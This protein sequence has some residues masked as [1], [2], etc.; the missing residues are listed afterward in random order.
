MSCRSPRERQQPAQDSTVPAGVPSSPTPWSLN[1]WTEKAL[2][3]SSAHP[4]ANGGISVRQRSRKHACHQLP[5]AT[6][7]PLRCPRKKHRKATAARVSRKAATGYTEGPS[8]HVSRSREGTAWH[9]A[10]LQS[11]P[12]P[13]PPS[14][15]PAFRCP[16]LPYSTHLGIL[17]SLRPGGS[18]VRQPL[19]FSVLLHHLKHELEGFPG[20][21]AHVLRQVGQLAALCPK[22]RGEERRGGGRIARRRRTWGAAWE[23]TC[24]YLLLRRGWI[25]IAIASTGHNASLLALRGCRHREGRRRTVH[26]FPGLE[27]FTGTT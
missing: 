22:R 23:S 14:P 27:A 2:F 1:D 19:R 6:Q 16:C 7:L 15:A 26:T 3:G 12:M 4:K 21:V 13:P 20:V 5:G 18:D 25:V 11:A 9:T 17:R 8:M 24:S 10:A